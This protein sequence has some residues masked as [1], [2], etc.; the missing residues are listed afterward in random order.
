MR[1]LFGLILAVLAP[2]ARADDMRPLYVE[3][4]LGATP[5]YAL[6]WRTPPSVARDAVPDLVLLEDCVRQAPSR[7]WSDG[8]GHWREAS[9]RCGMALPGVASSSGIPWEILAWRRSSR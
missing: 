4:R 7:H 6:T 2:V 8:S 1:S 5:R 9:W 3:A